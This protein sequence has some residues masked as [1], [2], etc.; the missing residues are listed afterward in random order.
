M[1]YPELIEIGRLG[2]LEPDGFYHVQF[3]QSDRK[4]VNQLT[5]CYLIFDSNRVFFVTVED[6]RN[7]GNRLYLKFLE[8]GICAEHRKPG[9]TII[10]LAKDDLDE[11][12]EDDVTD[13]FGYNVFFND[14]LIGKVEDAIVNPLQA[15]LI[16]ELIDGRE[17]MVPSVE[18]YIS[19]VNNPEK[20]VYMQNL[21][22]L[23][24]VCTSTS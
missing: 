17:L 7:V 1:N 24:E 4:V 10:A 9:Q 2:R 16:I 3:S 11:I 23:L 6:K 8:D 15:V 19:T 14:V 12:I 13:L 18:C 5:E 20:I 21:E 22:I